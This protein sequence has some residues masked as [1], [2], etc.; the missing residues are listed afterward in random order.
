M[1]VCGARWHEQSMPPT[2]TDLAAAWE[3]YIHASIDL[4]GADR[5]MFESNFPV[6][7]GMYS[8]RT[9]WNA[10]KRLTSGASVDEKASLFYA[11]AARIYGLDSTVAPTETVMSND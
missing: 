10:F 3:P 4:F 9:G 5:C 7:K 8:Y 1:I 11:T 2:S 6:D